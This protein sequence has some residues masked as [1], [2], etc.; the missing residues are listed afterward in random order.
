VGDGGDR[1]DFEFG[2]QAFP[3]D[4]PRDELGEPFVH[5]MHS[6]SEQGFGG[7][8]FFGGWVG[9]TPDGFVEEMQVPVGSRVSGAA[10]VGVVEEQRGGGM[11]KGRTGR[12]HQTTNRTLLT[13]CLR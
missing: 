9:A 10:F 5:F 7:E 3:Q 8:R 12:A 11:C 13:L 2:G 1:A 4:S 6:F